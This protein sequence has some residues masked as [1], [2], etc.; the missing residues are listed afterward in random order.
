MVFHGVP[1][2]SGCDAYDAIFRDSGFDRSAA[3]DMGGVSLAKGV[4]ARG[5][6]TV[7]VTIADDAMVTPAILRGW[8]RALLDHTRHPPEGQ[9]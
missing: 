5:Q 6:S 7:G 4:D 3:Y 1:F 2:Q 9:K 8:E